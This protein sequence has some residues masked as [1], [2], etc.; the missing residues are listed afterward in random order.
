MTGAGCSL[1]TTPTTEWLALIR[2]FKTKQIFGP[3]PNISGYHGGSFVTPNTEYVLAASRFSIP[4]PKGTVEP[5]E[6]YATKFKGIVAGLAI[7]P[8]TGNMSNGWQILMPPFDF[9]LATLARGRATAGP[10]GP[11]TTLS[12]R[13]GNSESYIHSKRSRLHHCRELREA[14]KA[15]NEGRGVQM[16]G[17]VK[18]T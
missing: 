7:D 18:G 11:V 2:D 6:D 13:S 15:A 17:G 14:E 12:A 9:D 10:S 8:T 4:L 16:I 1:M 5:M 3:V